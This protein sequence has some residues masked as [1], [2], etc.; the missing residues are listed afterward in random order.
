MVRECLTQGGKESYRRHDLFL[1]RVRAEVELA[2]SLFAHLFQV[3]ACPRY[4]WRPAVFFVDIE[5]YLI[6]G[7]WVAL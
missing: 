6:D 4:S 5:K 1:P 3:V 7:L 2:H